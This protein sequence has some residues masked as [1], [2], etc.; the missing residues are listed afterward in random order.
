MV[1]I[2]SPTANAQADAACG[3]LAIGPFRRLTA[4]LPGPKLCLSRQPHRVRHELRPPALTTPARRPGSGRHPCRRIAPSLHPR[5][6][7]SFPYIT[8]GPCCVD[9]A[10]RRGFRY[11]QGEK[12]PPILPFTTTMQSDQRL[13][14][15]RRDAPGPDERFCRRMRPG[16]DVFGTHKCLSSPRRPFVSAPCLFVLACIG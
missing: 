16:D 11:L 8:T 1:K 3:T 10:G 4:G 6:V 15:G 5:R 9:P 2:L 12:T 13:R 7:G 14:V